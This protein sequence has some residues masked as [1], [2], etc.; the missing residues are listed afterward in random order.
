MSE[1]SETY[2]EAGLIEWEREVRGY[3][4]Q[5]VDEVVAR[6]NSSIR[7]LKSSLSQCLAEIERLRG[8]LAD[9]REAGGRPPHEQISERVG[10]IL[11]LAED[12]AKTTRDRGAADVAD[13]R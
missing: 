3:N 5:Q 10:Q 12:E 6:Q 11:K 1:H 7:D 13:L 8:E 9:A 4:R 2:T